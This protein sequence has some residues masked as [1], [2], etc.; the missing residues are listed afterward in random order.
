MPKPVVHIGTDHAGLDLSHSL[1]E[2]LRGAGYTVV[3]HGPQSYDPV[4]DY[5]AFC[6]ATG[7]AVAADLAN[8]VAALGIVIGGSG[9]GE[10]ISA[11][12]VPGIRAALVWNHET[13]LLARQHNDANVV[14][15]GARQHSVQ[16]ATELVR[17]FLEE[18]FSG[19]ERHR[20]R[21]AQISA[22]EARRSS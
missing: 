15:V 14:A 22:Y 13:A 8:N 4:D 11:N 21:I 20:R 18:P 10:Q 5:P 2:T 7:E 3:D 12:K 16:E 1:I 19:A 17:A 6:I 9:N